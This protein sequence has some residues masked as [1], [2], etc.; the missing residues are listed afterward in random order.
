MVSQISL[1][2][3]NFRLLKYIHTI[4]EFK[5]KKLFFIILQPR[6]YAFLIKK[7]NQNYLEDRL[8]PLKL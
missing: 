8:V 5:K 1:M 2:Q 4:F 7:N 3:T 6:L